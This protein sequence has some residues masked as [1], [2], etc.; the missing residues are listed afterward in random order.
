MK[1]LEIPQIIISE[2]SFWPGFRQGPCFCF[3]M[4]SFLTCGPVLE[5]FIAMKKIFLE[6]NG[7]KSALKAF[8]EAPQVE[9]SPLEA[10]SSIMTASPGEPGEDEDYNDLGDI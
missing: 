8:Y 5:V 3:G 2:I 10:E 7:V 9:V 6:E 1:F 4:K